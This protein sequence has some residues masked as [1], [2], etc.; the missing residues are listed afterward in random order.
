MLGISHSLLCG[1]LTIQGIHP[2]PFVQPL[3]LRG[4]AP[5]VEVLSL[6]EKRAVELAPLLSPGFYSRLFVVMKAGH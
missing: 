4:K 2:L 3:V 6:V 1:P 5:D